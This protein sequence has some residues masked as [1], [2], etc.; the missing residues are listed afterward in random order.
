MGMINPPRGQPV[1]LQTDRFHLRTLR[2]D[3]ASERWSSWAKDPEVMAPLNAPVRNMDQQY[4]AGYAASF[5]NT[6]RFL[7]GIFDK[8]TE[9]H[10]GFFIV[11]VDR[12][13]RCATIHV[14]IGDKAWWGKGVANECRAALLDHFFDQ[15]GIEKACGVPLSHNVAAVSTFKKQGWRFEGTLR[16][17]RLSFADGSRLD[18]DQ[19]GLLRDEWK[20]LRQQQ[21]T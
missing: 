20:A 10:I 7:I 16:G 1:D 11:E 5:D 6:N 14:V 12:T 19:F 3:D 13:H 9:T 15:R 4:L 18:Q 2:P 21:K 17:Q 8:A